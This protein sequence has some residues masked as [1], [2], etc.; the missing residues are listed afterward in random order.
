VFGPGVVS[1]DLGQMEGANPVGKTGSAPANVG[2]A[3]IVE[4]ADHLCSAFANC[5]ELVS[6]NCNRG[7]GIL[8]GERPPET[9]AGRGIG[10]LDQ[11]QAPDTSQ[12]FQGLFVGS[13]HSQRVAG[14][15]VGDAVRENGAN[16]G[17]S[18]NIDEQLAQLVHARRQIANIG[19]Q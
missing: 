16:I 8:Q 10:Q 15:M 3:G 4:G 5:G 14:G 9:T 7:V 11:L 17:H 6:E 19:L 2:E 18:E 13:Q 1:Q 12:Q